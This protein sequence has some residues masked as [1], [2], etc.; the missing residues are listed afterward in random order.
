M[1]FLHDQTFSRQT[2]CGSPGGQACASAV[3]TSLLCVKNRTEMRK[4]MN[5]MNQR[6]TSSDSCP[7]NNC[8]NNRNMRNGMN[9]RGNFGNR[10]QYGSMQNNNCC[11]N[12]CN[13]SCDSNDC[14]KNSSQFSDS[15]QGMP[16]GM[17]YVPWQQWECTYSPEEGLAKGTIFP[18]LSLP[19]YGCIPRGYYCKGGQS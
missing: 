15:L 9:A 7:S 12:S 19:F 18:S 16:V 4:T 11:Q 3:I 6:M 10:A 13:N 1:V 5:N 17:G 2:A 8:M 14:D